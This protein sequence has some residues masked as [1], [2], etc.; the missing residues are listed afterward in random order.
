MLLSVLNCSIY[1]VRITL[2]VR[3]CVLTFVFTYDIH[4]CTGGQNNDS[5]I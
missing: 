1:D 3:R 2:N 5:N 4:V